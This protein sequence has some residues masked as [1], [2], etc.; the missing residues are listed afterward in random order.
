MTLSLHESYPPFWSFCIRY[1]SYCF[2][3]S[4]ASICILYFLAETIYLVCDFYCSLHLY[5]HIVLLPLKKIQIVPRSVVAKVKKPLCLCGHC[6]TL[7]QWLSWKRNTGLFM[8]HKFRGGG[9]CT[10]FGNLENINNVYSLYGC[11]WHI[12]RQYFEIG[13][14]ITNKN[15]NCP[16]SISNTELLKCV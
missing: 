1:T 4:T 12:E 13:S 16:L 2:F 14:I 3:S 8:P 11:E 6:L 5:C 7:F 9:C 10:T 15:I